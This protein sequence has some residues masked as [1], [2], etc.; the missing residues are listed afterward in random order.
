MRKFQA[1]KKI[2]GACLLLLSGAVF[3]NPDV[4]K[5]VPYYDI[6]RCL[7]TWYEIARTDH[8]LE[9]NL[10][11]TSAEFFV[12]RTGAIALSTRGLDSVTKK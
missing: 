10:E 11:F 2:F 12:D 9:K 3:A 7:G 5:A 4:V 6:S 1:L 8:L